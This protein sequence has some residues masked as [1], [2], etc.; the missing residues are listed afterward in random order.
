MKGNGQLRHEMRE[1]HLMPLFEAQC[2]TN[3]FEGALRT[4][5]KIAK[6]AHITSSEDHLMALVSPFETSKAVASDAY[7]ALL[8]V[9]RDES[10][11]GGVILHSM[12]AM[13]RLARKTGLHEMALKVYGVRKFLADGTNVG[14]KVAKS[15]LPKLP[16]FYLELGMNAAQVGEPGREIIRQT[17]TQIQDMDVVHEEAINTN[18]RIIRPDIST[19]NAL[20]GTAV[21]MESRELGEF[22]FREINAHKVKADETTY[23]RAIILFVV[24]PDYND[25]YD[26]LQ[27]CQSKGIRPTRASFL[28]IGLRCLKE[29]DDRWIRI[30]IE[31]VDHEYYPGSE[32]RQ[33]LLAGRHLS[34]ARLDRLAT[35]SRSESRSRV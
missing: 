19:F 22:V 2:N 16:T 23:E 25:A 29:N 34:P 24:Q 13:I 14:T 9:G 27:E 8:T 12:N 10:Q 26:F 35:F 21:D 32:L 6:L 7:K 11:D 28:A 3:D 4:A 30:G 1:W 18:K 31:M 17:I 33:A 15:V 20:L 5:T